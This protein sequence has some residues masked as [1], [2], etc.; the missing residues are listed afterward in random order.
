MT[1]SLRT[2]R[3]PGAASLAMFLAMGIAGLPDRPSTAAEPEPLVLRLKHQ[4]E[5]PGGSG[6]YRPVEKPATWDPAK[7]ALIVCDMWDLHHSL[8]ATLRLKE[9]AP[10]MNQTL[11]AARARGVLIIHAPSSCMDTYKD[12]PARRRATETPLSKNLPPEIGKWCYQIAS[13]AQ[14]TYPIDQRQGENDDDPTLQAEWLAKLAAMGR[15]PG[16]PWKSETDLLTI[17]PAVDVI[18]DKGDE[19]WSLLESRGIDHVI[20]TGVHTNMCVLG[21][22]FGLRQMT[23]NGKEAVLIGDLTDTIYNPARAPFVGHFAGTR[24]IVDHI[25][26]FVCPTITSDQLAGGA[27]FQFKDDPRSGTAEASD[28]PTLMT[29]RGKLLFQS[30]LDQSLTADWKTAKGRWEVVDG[31]I[32]GSELPADKHAAVT[33]HAVQF[34]NAVI[35]YSFKLDGARA[36]SLSL[37]DSKGHVCRVLITPRSFSVRKDDHDHDG[38]DKAVVFQTRTIVV[39]PGRWHTLTVELLGSEMLARLDDETVVLGANDAIDRDK[40]DFG[41]V[42]GGASASFKELRIWEALPNSDWASTRAKLAQ[43]TR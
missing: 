8:N 15:D 9:M 11:S 1:R 34:R 22:P 39:E 14:G 20:L 25:E 24:L 3:C 12:H 6:T 29:V 37:N 5:A 18:S 27:P 43:T 21:R 42:V 28:P 32:R 36:T 30:K 26:R 38:P 40:A 33:R 23:K 19:I 17:D 31:A 4:V 35:A 7:T 10:R 41:L 13:E 2:T 16:H